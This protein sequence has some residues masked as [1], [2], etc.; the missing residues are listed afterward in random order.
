MSKSLNLSLLWRN[1]MDDCW[2]QKNSRF[3][4]LV[5]FSIFFWQRFTCSL[6][7]HFIDFSQEISIIF[8]AIAIVRHFQFC[9]IAPYLDP[10]DVS[11]IF[12]LLKSLIIIRQKIG[13]K[14]PQK[15]RS[16]D[17]IDTGFE[18][19]VLESPIFNRKSK[20]IFLKI[21]IWNNCWLSIFWLSNMSIGSIF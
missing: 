18:S 9:T 20:V 8:Y 5:T 11:K 7:W 6:V 12:E 19:F 4:H 1:I 15:W 2:H 14:S 3:T 16:L 17:V 13:Q 21:F 10:N